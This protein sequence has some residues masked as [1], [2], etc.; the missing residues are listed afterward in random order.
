MRSIVID[1]KI[2]D[3]CGICGSKEPFIEYKEIEGIPF[4]WCHKCN[5]INF[6]DYV[7]NHTQ[8]KIENIVRTERK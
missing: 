3:T 6:F 8:T 5:T 2:N 1:K 7:D 4:I